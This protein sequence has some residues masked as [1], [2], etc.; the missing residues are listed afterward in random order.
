MAHHPSCPDTGHSYIY[1]PSHSPCL[2]RIYASSAGGQS[3]PVMVRV[4]TT[5]T[6]SSRFLILPPDTEEDS[7]DYAAPDTGEPAAEESLPFSMKVVMFTMVMVALILVVFSASLG[8]IC[9]IQCRVSCDLA[10]GRLE[11]N[12]LCQFVEE[13]QRLGVK[14]QSTATSPMGSSS[15]LA[16]DLLTH[17]HTL[18]CE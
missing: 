2:F 14:T 5:Q 18:H 15:S 13:S 9:R 6:E 3:Q 17:T 7:F 1:T 16:P 12:I 11:G 8:A 4:S 10:L